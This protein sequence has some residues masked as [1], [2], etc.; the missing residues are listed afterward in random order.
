M[1]QGLGRQSQ[2]M[3]LQTKIAILEAR[4]KQLGR[5]LDSAMSVLH[6]AQ[7]AQLETQ[8]QY[9]ALEKKWNELT[10]QFHLD[11]QRIR[12]LEQELKVSIRKDDAV[13]LKQMTEQL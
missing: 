1:T 9:D 6:H 10:E 7:Q 2:E 12:E 11:K 3:Q 5:K 13:N 8:R 4:E